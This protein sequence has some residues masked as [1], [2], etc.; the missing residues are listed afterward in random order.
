MT[1]IVGLTGGIGS[2]KSL[3]ASVFRT[4][5]IPV[6]DADFEARQLTDTDRL[7]HNE[8]LAW[9]GPDYFENGRLNRPMVANLVFRDPSS[10]EKLNSII[11]PRVRAHFQEWVM[12]NSNAPYLVHEAAIL[13]E[14]GFYK[15]MDKNILVT[16]P[17][18]IRIRRIMERDGVTEESARSRMSH[19]WDD[20]R[21]IPMADY[22]IK[23]AGD[24][25]MVP[26]IINIHNQL[27]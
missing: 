13:F 27:K 25:L 3:A 20:E 11:H 15:I 2:G 12:T 17:A 7:I 5:G 4:L 14:S 19:Q 10:L 24:E 16:C 22:V 9:I 26:Q 6:Y 21:K 1:K 18:E 23:N 8:L